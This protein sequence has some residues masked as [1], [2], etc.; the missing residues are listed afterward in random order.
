M[1]TAK[2]D[3]FNCSGS[4]SVAHPL[5]GMGGLKLKQPET[6]EVKILINNLN[7]TLKFVEK[8]K[9]EIQQN[10]LRMLV[11]SYKLRITSQ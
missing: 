11:S 9:S 4:E 6:A 5:H 10:V 3:E 7:V 2:Q 1:N 8:P